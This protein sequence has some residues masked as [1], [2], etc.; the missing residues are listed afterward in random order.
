MNYTK[1]WADCTITLLFACAE[2]GKLYYIYVLHSYQNLLCFPGKDI[3]FKSDL[4]GARRKAASWCVSIQTQVLLRPTEGQRELFRIKKQFPS[5]SN[6]CSHYTLHCLWYFHSRCHKHWCYQEK[7]P[8]FSPLWHL[9]LQLVL[10]DML[11]INMFRTMEDFKCL[12]GN[13]LNTDIESNS[14]QI[15]VYICSL[16]MHLLCHNYMTQESGMGSHKI[17]RNESF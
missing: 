10:T 1:W 2:C 15:I 6:S 8:I 16:C 9:P 5:T 4:F 11:L 3:Y 12:N 7:P 13:K 14:K 17:Q